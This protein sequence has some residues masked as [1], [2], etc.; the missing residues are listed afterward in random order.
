MKK[1]GN[2]IKKL[3]F[4]LIPPIFLL[5]MISAAVQQ[6]KPEVPYVPT[7]EKVVLEMLKMADVGRNDVLYDL[8]CGD[9]RIVITA[10]KRLGCRGV[11]FDIDPQ[12]IKESRENA[13]KQG[14]SDQVE[15]FRLDLF[16]ADISNATVVTLYLLSSVNLRL[17]PKL[18]RELEPG[19][20]VVSHDFDMGTWKAEESIIIYD[21]TDDY[22]PP[23]DPLFFED[24][25]DKHNVYFWIIP[26]N[27][28]GTWKWTM[29]DVSG[30]KP[31]RL[32]LNQ[33]FQVVTGKAFE[34]SSSISLMIKDGKIIGNKLEFSLERKLRGRSEKIHFEG[35]VKENIM[36]GSARIG[37]ESGAKK[38]WRAK[39]DPS[40]FKSIEK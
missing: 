25:W 30:Q 17:R 28:T 23:Y 3:F 24:Y 7:P 15:F 39:R 21:S 38:K 6:E 22:S 35:L 37:G 19:T 4:I 1:S 31:F 5:V 33:S 10:A 32:E 13:L 18:F 16:K 12:R 20:R 26:A 9:G 40:T 36:E 29:P 14:V 11:G 27:V 8:G 2:P 34:G